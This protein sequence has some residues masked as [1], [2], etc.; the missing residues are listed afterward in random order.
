[1]KD[2]IKPEGK[3][4]YWWIPLISGL[5]LLLFGIW[6]LVAPID[7][8]QTLTVIFGILILLSGILEIYIIVKDKGFALEFISYIWGGILSILLGALLI[9]NP[10]LI[11]VIISVLIGFWLIF[12]GG[13]IIKKALKIRKENNDKWKNHMFLGVMLFV[14]AIILLWHP[15]I[16]GFTIAMWTSI[17][18]IVL[19]AF[20]IYLALRMKS[21]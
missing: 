21:I 1:M 15:Q 4:I 12:K 18:F 14:V 7:S 13:E 16:I 17:A 6:F 10:Q 11:L 9:T 8:F 5:F 20:R 2:V 19:G 3:Q